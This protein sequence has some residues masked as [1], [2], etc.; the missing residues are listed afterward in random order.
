MG[1]RSVS[2]MME[3]K[4]GKKGE[5]ERERKKTSIETIFPRQLSNIIISV[6]PNLN[7]WA[8]ISRSTRQIESVFIERN[9]PSTATD[10][11]QFLLFRKGGSNVFGSW[12][13]EEGGLLVSSGF[14]RQTREYYDDIIFTINSP[15]VRATSF[16]LLSSSFLSILSLAFHSSIPITY[17]HCLIPLDPLSVAIF[18]FFFEEEEPKLSFGISNGREIINGDFKFKL[19]RSESSMRV[20][21]RNGREMK[22]HQSSVLPPPRSF[23][24]S[25]DRGAKI[26]TIYARGTWARDYYLSAGKLRG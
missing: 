9:F 1:G 13:A 21:Q 25:A 10:S 26:S 15:R 23:A 20:S 3:N 18:P 17:R 4:G 19:E 14:D 6:E 5:R 8:S 2:M 24:V 22:L 7:L 16:C 11:K 12:T